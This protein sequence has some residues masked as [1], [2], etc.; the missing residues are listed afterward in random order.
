MLSIGKLGRVLGGGAAT[1]VT[2]MIQSGIEMGFR[3]F[4]YEN[5]MKELKQLDDE[6]ASVKQGPSDLSRYNGS[7]AG[8]FK[9]EQAFAAVTLPEVSGT[10]PLPTHDPLTDPVF[11]LTPS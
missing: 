8:R 4:E 2:L 11:Y 3:V 7:G 6:Y 5:A 1:V 10:A 9:V